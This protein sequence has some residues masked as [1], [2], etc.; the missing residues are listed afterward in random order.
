MSFGGLISGGSGN[1]GG[2]GARVVADI[3]PHTPYMSSGAIAQPHFLT[4]PVPN[5]MRSSSALSLSI[6]NMDGHSELGLIAEN[7]DPGII[8]RMRDDEYESRSG[9]DNLKAHQVMIKRPGTSDA[10]G[11]R[12]II[13]IPQAKFKNLKIS[14]KNVLILMKSRGLS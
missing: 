14:S 10:P 12:S 7:F 8:G 6:K 9:S 5:S 2:G 13:G 4:S 11:K 1:S 3:A